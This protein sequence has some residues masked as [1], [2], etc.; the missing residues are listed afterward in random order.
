[1]VEMFNARRFQKIATTYEFMEKLQLFNCFKTNPRFPPFLLYARCKSWVTFVRRCFRD[2]SI[3]GTSRQHK[4]IQDLFLKVTPDL[5]LIRG[6]DPRHLVYKASGFTTKLR[7]LLLCVY[8]IV[9]FESV[10]GLH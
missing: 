9:P 1:M 10:F 2:Y 8:V 5:H 7:K 3:N 6:L 4:V